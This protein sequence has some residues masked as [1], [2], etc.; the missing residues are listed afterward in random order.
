MNL[1]MA[2]TADRYELPVYVADSVPELARATGRNPASIHAA[3]TLSYSGKY[4]GI[5]FLKVEVSECST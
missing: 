4:G 3:I 5:K 2:V 1:Y